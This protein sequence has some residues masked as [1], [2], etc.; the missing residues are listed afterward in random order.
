MILDIS[1]FSGFPHGLDHGRGDG[2]VDLP[3]D[4]SRVGTGGVED[5]K[6]HECVSV[7]VSGSR[8]I[9][10]EGLEPGVHAA[11]HVV[12]AGES[13][14]REMFGCML[15]APPHLAVEDEKRVL[16]EEE[17]EAEGG[18][19]EKSPDILAYTLISFFNKK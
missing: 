5:L 2:F 18:R 16:E 4:F 15:T 14:A 3:R 11:H 1:A 8:G 10:A 12:D 13:Q 7:G 9:G 17:G 6:C 19:S